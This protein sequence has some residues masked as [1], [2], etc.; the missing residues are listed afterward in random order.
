MKK[1]GTCEKD[2]IYSTEFYQ[3]KREMVGHCLLKKRKDER[4]EYTEGMNSYRWSLACAKKL[5]LYSTKPPNAMTF[6]FCLHSA[7]LIG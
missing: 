7:R 5:L 4:R 6:E 2:V 3:K 1:K